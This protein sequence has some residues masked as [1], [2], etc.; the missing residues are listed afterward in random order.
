VST[1][2]IVYSIHMNT[3]G[4][5]PGGHTPAIADWLQPLASLQLSTALYSSLQLSSTLY[6]NT[7]LSLFYSI[8]FTY[9]P[10]Y[11]VLICVEHQHAVYGL[12][13]HLKRHQGLPAARRKE[14][15]AAYA[16]LAI[17]APTQLSLPAH[18][19]APIA[20]LGRAQDA[21]LCCQQEKEEAGAGAGAAAAV[22]QR[23]SC[24]YITTNRLEMRKHTN[25]QHSALQRIR[26]EPFQWWLARLHGGRVIGFHA[27]LH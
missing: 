15:R 12:D 1:A 9:L 8:M 16:G 22:Q 24:S 10:A 11:R 3:R 2:F 18:N 17:D 5:A 4:N 25:Q 27:C 6:N 7:R 26:Y 19:S 21:F 13:E 14:L 20:E 23:R